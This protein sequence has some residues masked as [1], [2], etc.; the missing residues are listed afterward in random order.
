MTYRELPANTPQIL[1][2]AGLKVREV[3]GW[4]DRGRPASTGG[5][6]P[7]GVLCH[8]TAT[9]PNV[10][11]VALI[12]LLVRGRSDL[13]GPLCHFALTRDGT[14][15]IVAAGRAN[16]AG[17]AKSSGTV[18][19]GDGNSLYW[20]IEAANSGTGE[21]WPKAQYDAYVRLCAVLCE[22][23]TGNSVNTV[24]AHRETSVTGKI[25]PHGPTPYGS[26][27]DMDQFRAKVSVAMKPATPEPKR[28]TRGPNIDAAIDRTVAARKAAKKP[29]RKR[30]LQS[31]VK[32]LRALP[33]INRKK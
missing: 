33:V 12:D 8:H 2:D 27:F 30:R 6:N 10:S 32:A 18:A 17:R 3:P 13:P 4:R 16:H 11:D 14:V 20:G 1:R 15:H 28:P 24:R 9:G 5:L 23:V 21:P 22:K 19:G 26:T 29:A 7:A 31:I 25:D